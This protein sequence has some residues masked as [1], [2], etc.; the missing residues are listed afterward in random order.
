DK[1][2]NKRKSTIAKDVSKQ[3][4]DICRKPTMSAEKSKHKSQASKT[5]KKKDEEDEDVVMELLLFGAAAAGA[6]CVMCILTWLYWFLHNDPRGRL[7]MDD[8]LMKLGYDTYGGWE[9]AFNDQ[10]SKPEMFCRAIRLIVYHILMFTSSNIP[11]N[12]PMKMNT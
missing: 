6:A 2:R 9:S 12:K 1:Q 10:R 11:T 3:T 8:I 7:V 5:R 4:G